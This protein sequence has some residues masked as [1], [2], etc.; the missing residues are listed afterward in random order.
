[1]STDPRRAS[2]S[3]P[4][5]G[6]DTW[7]DAP[8]IEFECKRDEPWTWLNE[9]TGYVETIDYTSWSIRFWHAFEVNFRYWLSE[10]EE[11]S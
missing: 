2:V 7:A 3:L 5:A 6:P 4:D 9:E 10:W 8:D 1:M 11:V